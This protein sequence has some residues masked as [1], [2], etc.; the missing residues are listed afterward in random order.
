MSSIGTVKIGGDTYQVTQAP[1]IEQKKLLT[2][3]GARIAAVSASGQVEAINENLVYGMLLTAGEPIV[4]QVAD[5]VL[6]QC[7]KVGVKE[8]VTVDNFQ[9]NIH[10]YFMLLAKA[11]GVNL[12]DFFIYLDSVNAETR[13]KG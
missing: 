6:H 4:D 12:N 11:I 5:I 8:L 7:A 1:A 9:N 10:N 2:L 13:A 3:I